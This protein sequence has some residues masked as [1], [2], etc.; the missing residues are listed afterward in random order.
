MAIDLFFIKMPW[1]VDVV[2]VLVAFLFAVLL[3]SWLR[4]YS[5][6]R[7]EGGQ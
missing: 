1:L 4:S 3:R 2:V 6:R 5:R 7:L